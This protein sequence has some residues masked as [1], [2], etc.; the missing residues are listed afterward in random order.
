VRIEVTLLR[1]ADDGGED[2]LRRGAVRRA[3]PATDFSGH[4]SG[5][6][7]LFGTPV[8]RVDP[9]RLK[10]KREERGPFDGEMRREPTH[11]GDP[12]RA[13]Q[14]TTEA[15][16]EVTAGDR[17]AMGRHA[18]R[19]VVVAERQCLLQDL[20]HRRDK[21]GARVIALQQATAPQQMREARLM[22]GL[23][24]ATIRRPAVA[25]DHAGEVLAEQCGGFRITAARQDRIDG[26]RGRR[27]GPQPVQMAGDFPARFIRGHDGAAAYLLT[28]GR[29]GGL[30]LAC[31]T[32]DGVDQSAASDGQAVLLAKQR[33]DLAERE[34]ELLI[35]NHGKGD[36]LRAEL[37]AR[38][39]ERVGG[40]QGVTSLHAPAA[41][42]ARP[43][44]NA[45]LT[46]DDARDREFF[47]GLRR[48]PRLAQSAAAV[49]TGA[50]QR[51][52]VVLIHLP[53]PSPMRFRAIPPPGFASR[54]ARRPR[55][56]FGEG[57]RLAV[58]STPRL[59]ELPLQAIIVAP[60]SIAFAFDTLQLTA[61]A[62]PFLLR[63]FGALAQ[64][65][66]LVWALIGVVAR[67]ALRHATSMARSRN[68]YKYGILDRERRDRLRFTTR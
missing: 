30:R 23:G 33:G 17:E 62:I 57:G 21:T 46:H 1:G 3:V 7:R 6:Q 15:F 48:D 41:R 14:L 60:Q 31:R 39:P 67:R 13:I 55:Q 50:R 29:I 49:R 56:G 26:G 25:H 4:D 24:E 58:R 36:H 8:G 22:H 32:M 20:F 34:A 61:Q 68:L 51:H 40:L 12:A 9:R 19:E 28:Q 65:I 2:L 44:V 5:P 59:V 66:V 35:E 53:R 38:R 10:E 47:L 16:D 64:F 42:A 27:R 52:L 18:P 45:K 11:V 63:P 43:D 54:S 37:G